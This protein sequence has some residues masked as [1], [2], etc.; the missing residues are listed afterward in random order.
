MLLKCNFE[1]IHLLLNIDSLPLS[2]SSNASLWPILISNT[3]Q[4]DVYIVGAYF[5]KKDLKIQ[6]FFTT[7]SR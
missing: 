2:K 5:G 3:I 1:H 6:M 7:F 4:N